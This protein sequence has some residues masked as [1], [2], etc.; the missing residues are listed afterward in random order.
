MNIVDDL[1]W[2]LGVHKLKFGVDGRIVFLDIDPAVGS[3]GYSADSV[4]DFL[5]TGQTNLYT[6]TTSPAQ[7]KAPA[8]SLYA[9]DTWSVTQRLTLS[10]GLRWELSPAPSARGNTSWL[11]GKMSTILPRSLL[12]R[13]ARHSGRH[14]MQILPHDSGWPID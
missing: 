10:Y 9:Q 8:L 7:V 4:Q 3:L 13:S 6:T 12:R 2:A 1:S 11:P 14:S 5:A